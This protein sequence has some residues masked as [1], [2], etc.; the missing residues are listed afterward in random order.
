MFQCGMPK[1][2]I[3]CDSYTHK[4][5]ASDKHSPFLSSRV[6]FGWCSK[7]GTEVFATEIC[8]TYEAMPGIT[9]IDVTNRPAPKEPRQEALF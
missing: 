1:A 9:L 8:N 5:Y 6:Q 4:G 2:C 3:S 7:S